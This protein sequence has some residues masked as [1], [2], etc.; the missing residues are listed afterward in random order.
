MAKVVMYKT[1]TCQYCRMM[2]DYLD[3][4]NVVHEDK[5]VDEDASL[6]A[7]MV[8]KSGGV[9]AVP[10][11]LILD[12]K[13]NELAQG[14]GFNK[15][16]LNQGLAKAGVVFDESQAEGVKEGQTQTGIG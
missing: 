5:Y 14:L 2:S 10:F 1:K 12:D 16:E 7:E 9:T 6:A 11:W 13:G 3:R 4:N 15:E 8:Q